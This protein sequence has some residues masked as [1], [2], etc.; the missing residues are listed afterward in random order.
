MGTL[1][2]KLIKNGERGHKLNFPDDHTEVSIRR[3]EPVSSKYIG[4][5]YNKSRSKW[6]AKRWSKNR[7]KRL[8]NGCF[9]NEQTAAH[10]SDA[11]ARKLIENGEHHELNFPDV[12]AEVKKKPFASK[13]AGVSYH[14]NRWCAQ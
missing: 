4:V 6:Y 11:L 8:Q 14:Q 9:D 13:Y 7:N 2:R 1:A 12:Y 3:K 10:V 5:H